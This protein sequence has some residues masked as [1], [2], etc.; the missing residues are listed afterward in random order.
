L[1]H[2]SST[3]PRQLGRKDIDFF[4]RRR[5]CEQLGSFRHQRRRD[6]ARKVGLPARLVWERVEVTERRGPQFEPV[7]GNRRWFFL[8]DRQAAKK[9]FS[10]SA[11]FPGL[12]SGLTNNATFTLFPSPLTMSISFP[13]GLY[14]SLR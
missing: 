9:E 2:S 8:N 4:D 11:S 13:L 10:T 6:F 5:L 14:V 3:L 12:A 7:P 1:R